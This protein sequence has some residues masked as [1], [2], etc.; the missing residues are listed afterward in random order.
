MIFEHLATVGKILL[1]LRGMSHRWYDQLTQVAVGKSCDMNVRMS[2][3]SVQ[4]LIAI[5][6]FFISSKVF[7]ILLKVFLICLSN[8]FCAIKNSF[9]LAK[10]VLSCH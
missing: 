5:E 6:A 9:S 8:D 2:E 1:P 10:S 4:C 7:F 3:N